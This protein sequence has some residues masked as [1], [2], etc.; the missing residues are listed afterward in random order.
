M[1]GESLSRLVHMVNANETVHKKMKDFHHQD[2]MTVMNTCPVRSS[3]LRSTR[4]LRG[5]NIFSEQSNE[6]PEKLSDKFGLSGE[7]ISSNIRILEN[8][9]NCLESRFKLMYKYGE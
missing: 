6:C 1:T 8:M 4:L 2:E 7:P 5:G 9:L 3:L